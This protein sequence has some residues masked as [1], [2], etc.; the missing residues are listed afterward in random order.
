MLI[1]KKSGMKRVLFLIL[2]C[3]TTL[4]TAQQKN[5]SEALKMVLPESI[6]MAAFNAKLDSMNHSYP[7]LKEFDT[8]L[9]FLK[10][11]Y[12]DLNRGLM[13][14]PLQKFRDISK[15]HF[16]ETYQEMHEQSYLRKAFQKTSGN[17]LFNIHNYRERFKTRQ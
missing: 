11:N 17:N 13:T 5:N 16:Y 6:Y 14:V 2:F 8:S 9:N 3:C 10:Y 1:L 7:L 15:V 4:L 12:I